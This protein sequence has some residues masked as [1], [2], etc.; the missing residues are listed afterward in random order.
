MESVSR[1]S[2]SHKNKSKKLW[3]IIPL[4]L[5]GVIILGILIYVLVFYNNAK[6]LVNEKMHEAVS[7]IDTDLT[8]IKLKSTKPL[9]VLLL[10]IDTESGDAGR[11]DAIIIMQ[12]QPATNSIQMVSI[13]RDARTEIIGM[14]FEDKINHAYAFGAK[15]GQ[16]T[17]GRAAMSVATVE[18]FLGIELDYYVSI[19]MKGL[20]E[21]VNELGSITVNNDVEWSEGNY[22]F[23]KGALLM[24]GDKTK[25]YVR[26]RKKDPNGDF[27]RT[28]R[29]RKVIEAILNEGASIGSIPKFG[30]MLDVLGKNI[31]TNMDF[32]DMKKLFTGYADTR[33]TINEHMMTGTGQMMPNGSGTKSYYL[34][35]PESEIK[36][37]HDLL[38]KNN[39]E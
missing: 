11:S 36:E 17:A 26:M 9:N 15:D 27:G 39:P 32:D 1:I 21:L 2:R 3:W 16:G 10:G 14:G 38:T 30:G 23:P 31:Q 29:Q 37:A 22:D 5:I 28:T 18:N 25:S 6:S 4:S 20:V 35:V 8:K 33:R 13:P 7:T 12:L 24:D 19:N 34:V